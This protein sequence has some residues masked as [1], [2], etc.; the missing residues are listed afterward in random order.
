[1]V[2]GYFRSRAQ[3]LF[4]STKND[5][6]YESKVEDLR[7]KKLNV[8]ITKEEITEFQTET[9]KLIVTK[10]D[11]HRQT[12]EEFKSPELKDL[13]NKNSELERDMKVSKCLKDLTTNESKRK[14][15]KIKRTHAKNLKEKFAKWTRERD[16]ELK[17]IADKKDDL[18]S[19]YHE[20]T[21]RVLH[22]INSSTGRD[23]TKAEKKLSTIEAEYRRKLEKREAE[24]Q[25][26]RHE[27]ENKIE[28][29]KNDQQKEIRRFEKNTTSNLLRY[30]SDMELLCENH[31]VTQKD[32]CSN[33]ENKYIRSELFEL[34]KKQNS[35]ISELE[36]VCHALIWD[37]KHL[38]KHLEYN[39][40]IRESRPQNRCK[41]A[42][43]EML[44]FTFGKNE[45][46]IQSC[47]KH[48][49][50]ILLRYLSKILYAP[51]FD[52]K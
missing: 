48:F 1:M 3:Q 51:K 15:E 27:L 22:Q 14:L 41:S 10:F 42:G 28:K 19:Q 50:C 17:A 11:R 36:E 45:N 52:M 4:S 38:E 40:R 30:E 44:A 9:T 12:I 37:N 26:A 6:D 13:E 21:N 5:L 31:H 18:R 34:K 35:E 29:L 43:G 47:F 25:N 24:E 7:D 16:Q 23:K 46:M 2:F 32:L 20:D 8:G 33:E 39:I 49:S